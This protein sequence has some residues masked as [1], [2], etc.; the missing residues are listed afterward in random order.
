MNVEAYLIEAHVFRIINGNMEFLVLKRAGS[1]IYP[2]IWQMVTGSI[3][4]SEKA[5]ETAMRE[6]KEETG[7]SIN[8]FWVVPHVNSFYSPERDS[9]CM[10]PVFAAQVDPDA[11]V[12][13]SNEHSEYRW[14]RIDAAIES[15][16]WEG[17]RQS[18][19]IIEQYF[20]NEQSTLNFVDL[21]EVIS[22][23]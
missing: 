7:L 8:R 12:V 11:D 18:A 20:I 2:G 16:A 14:L 21:S 10:V 15:F 17:Q 22:G 5:S 13:I 4:D 23:N 1:E 19:K 6:I 9:I 3:N